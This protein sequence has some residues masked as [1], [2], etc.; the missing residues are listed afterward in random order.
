MSKKN[1]LRSKKIDINQ[2]S[3]VP[4]YEKKEQKID[5]SGEI[6][7]RKV[8]HGYSGRWTAVLRNYDKYYDLL[9]QYKEIRPF[10]DEVRMDDY[11]INLKLAKPLTSYLASTEYKYMESRYISYQKL[12]YI[13]EPIVIREKYLIDKRTNKQLNT[14]YDND[15]IVELDIYCI[16]DNDCKVFNR[17]V[18]LSEHFA[19]DII[20]GIP[21]SYDFVCEGIP[22]IPKEKVDDLIDDNSK[23]YHLSIKNR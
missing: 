22:Y 1:F 5:Y 11:L 13:I 21:I 9:D 7:S 2:I 23:K 17:Q 14:Y 12:L 4:I 18:E 19:I 3:I 15:R 8:I 16:K 6:I 20:L 10:D